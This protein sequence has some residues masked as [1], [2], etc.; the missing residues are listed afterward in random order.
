MKISSIL[1][2]TVLSAFV[3]WGCE[4]KPQPIQYG[5]EEC[6]YCRMIITDAEFASQ[7]VNNQGRSYKFDSVEC[8]AAFELT[9]GNKNNIHSKWV[10]DFQNN[11]E[12]INAESAVFLH[13]ETLR[14]PMGLYLSAYSSPADA[15]AMRSEYGGEIM[16]YRE[17]LLLVEQEWSGNLSRL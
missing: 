14:S 11:N 13:S 2:L 10:P 9:S 16:S 4:P 7:I 12:W 15:E 17:V 5:N 3:L 8:M 1:F 6:A